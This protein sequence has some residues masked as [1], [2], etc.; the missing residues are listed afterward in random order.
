MVASKL[1]R[2]TFCFDIV[3]VH[4]S[5]DLSGIGSLA[6]ELALRHRFPFSA[7]HQQDYHTHEQDPNP[8]KLAQASI[9]DAGPQ[10]ISRSHAKKELE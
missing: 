6:N 1:C 5:L 9:G 7:S 2:Y 3:E 10:H 8:N 4:T